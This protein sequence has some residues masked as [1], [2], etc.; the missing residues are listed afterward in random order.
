M[1]PYLTDRYRNINRGR[2]QQK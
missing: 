2:Y 1:S